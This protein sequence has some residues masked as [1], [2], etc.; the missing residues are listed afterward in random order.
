[1]HGM[2]IKII[3]NNSKTAI[4]VI[5]KVVTVNVKNHSILIIP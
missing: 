4:F 2:N 1:M 3:I 5:Y